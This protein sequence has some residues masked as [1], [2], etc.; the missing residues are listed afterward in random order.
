VADLNKVR[1][2]IPGSSQEL[3]VRCPIEEILLCGTRG[4]AKSESVLMKFAQHCGRGYDAFWQG[5]IFR[6]EFKHLHDIVQKAKQWFPLMAYK[7]RFYESASTYKFV[8]PRGEQLLFRH[9]KGPGDYDS[10]HGHEYPFQAWEELTGWPD[11]EGY[12]LMQSCMRTSYVPENN[13]IVPG[14][15]IP[16]HQCATTNP[17]GVGHNWVKRRWNLPNYGQVITD[18]DTGLKRI[19]IFGT[20]AENPHVDPRYVQRIRAIKEPNK[21]KAWVYGSWD[22]TSGGMFDDIWDS[23]KHILRPF[24]IPHSW[25][26]DRAFDWGSAKPFSVGWW[27]TS[28]GS[29][30]TMADGSKR[31]FPAGSKFRIFEWYGA[32][33]DQDNVGLHYTSDK[34]ARGIL[35]RD[36]FVVTHFGQEHRD[37]YALNIRPGPADSS[38]F[39]TIDRVNIARD[40]A[41]L[42]VRW[43]KADKR[44]GSRKNGWAVIRG[45]LEATVENRDTPHLYTFDTCPHFIRLFPILPRSEKDLDDVDT[46]AEDHIGDETRY[47]IL[48]PS[49]KAAT[50]NAVGI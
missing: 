18:P 44:P 33:D 19:A 37:R 47:E 3:F 30:A 1:E 40:M 36:K 34:I 17:S 10:F 11:P 38:I 5:L 39:D 9:F 2:P 7:P 43:K 35:E 48:R 20:L 41:K 26:V 28:D 14:L 8:W 32:E 42:G 45:M 22:I 23:A 16:M 29:E 13:V 25:T 4:A 49:G 12:I 27:A 46:E 50:V 21:R 31:T 24:R 6:R 15:P